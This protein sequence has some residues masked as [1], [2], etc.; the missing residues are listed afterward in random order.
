MKLYNHLPI[1]IRNFNASDIGIKLQAEYHPKYVVVL[2]SA[3]WKHYGQKLFDLFDL[4]HPDLWE[5]Y[6]KFLEEYYK[7]LGMTASYGP[8]Y[9]NVC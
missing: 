8:P 9:E 4:R 3:V 1:G 6:R 5:E 7:L 2:Q